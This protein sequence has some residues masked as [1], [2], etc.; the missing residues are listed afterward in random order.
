MA[1]I[2]NDII[3]SSNNAVFLE[4]LK[5]DEKNTK[6]ILFLEP[7]KTIQ[8]WEIDDAEEVFDKINDALNEGYFVA[9]YF[10][11]EAGYAFDDYLKKLCFKN[12]LAPIIWLGV[13]KEA[14]IFRDS[15][16]YIINNKSD[17]RLGETSLDI[18][19]GEYYK[20]IDKI[21]EHIRKGNV[22]QINFTCKYNFDFIGDPFSLYSRLRDKQR[23][24]YAAFIK[25]ADTYIIS[26]SPELFLRI[27]GR[28]ITARPMKG[29]IRRGRS[30]SEDAKL[31]RALKAS[32][33]D[34]AENIMIVDLI[35]ND[36]GRICEIGSVKA[37]RI[38]EIEKYETLFQMTSVVKGCLKRGVGFYE[39][40]KSAFPSGSVTG[41]P[42]LK[43]MEIIKSLERKPR[44]VYTGAIGYFSPA[45][46][47]VFNVAIRTIMIKG[48]KGQ[49]GIGS[50]ITWSSRCEDEYNECLLKANFLTAVENPWVSLNFRLVETILCRG[51]KYTFLK[52]H[53]KRMKGSADYFAFVFDC[54][55][56]MNLL[57]NNLKFLDSSKKY[58][59]RILLDKN[60]DVQIE[61]SLIDDENG[62][63]PYYAVISDK[64]V[65]S[66]NVF[67][68]HKTDNRRL[69]DEAYQQARKGGFFDVIFTN[70]KGEV[71]EGSITNI[72]IKKDNKFITPPVSCGLLNGIYRQRFIAR[73]K[74]VLEKAIT[75]QELLGA[76][77]VYLCNSVRGMVRVNVCFT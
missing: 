25:H 65:D 11:Y 44:G 32:E 47:A 58:K 10:T 7:I 76:D 4:T 56:I 6:T 30:L 19:K 53:L 29:T 28:E 51:G 68:Y 73:F 50:G 18:S 5:Y 35:R 15:S 36:L 22:Y 8:A 52:W 77:E 14:K 12:A 24:G 21:K 45:G 60:G 20:N 74:G 71:T 2:M 17:Y 57:K 40:F 9:G 39:I 67:L 69:Y 26:L 33:K 38:F 27:E 3:S 54:A 16:D 61:N 55:K 31:G 72:F 43:S 62:R 13:Y 70:E 23:V 1:F 64:K 42:K 48:N 59:V 41:A 37:P 75:I 49:M 66:G 63:H 46:E 34:R